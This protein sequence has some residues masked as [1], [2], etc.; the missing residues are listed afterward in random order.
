[1]LSTSSRFTQTLDPNAGVARRAGASVVETAVS[2]VALSGFCVST[3]SGYPTG[4]FGGSWT[5]IERKPMPKVDLHPDRWP[6]QST[7]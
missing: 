2:G 4:N 7:S 5:A 3:T 6:L 1:M